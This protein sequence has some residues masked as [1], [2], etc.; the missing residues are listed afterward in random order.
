M[1]QVF[2]T[3]LMHSASLD[4][5]LQTGHIHESPKLLLRVLKQPLVDVGVW[6]GLAL[7]TAV[8]DFK[9]KRGTFMLPFSSWL[10]VWTVLVSFPKQE[11]FGDPNGVKTCLPEFV[12]L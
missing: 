12:N 5:A 7:S 10:L 11:W 6:T 8:D 2:D 9:G 1:C 4:L 3:I